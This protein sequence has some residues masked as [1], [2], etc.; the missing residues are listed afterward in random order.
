MMGRRSAYFVSR[1]REVGR[2]LVVDVVDMARL[3]RRWVLVNH[4]YDYL[5][6]HMEMMVVQKEV[7]PK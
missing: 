1:C 5:F 3:V 6:R 2:D 4:G 7:G